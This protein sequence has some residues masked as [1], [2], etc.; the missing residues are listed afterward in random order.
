M[1]ACRACGCTDDNCSRCIERTGGRCWWV[2]ADLCSACEPDPIKA[3]TALTMEASARMSAWYS[4]PGAMAIVLDRR[5]HLHLGAALEPGPNGNPM[6]LLEHF[7]NIAITQIAGVPENRVRAAQLERAACVHCRQ[8]VALVTDVEAIRLHA[9]TCHQSPVVQ[10]LAGSR[11]KHGQLREL[12]EVETRARAAAAAELER[13]KNDQELS[14]T[15][16]ATARNELVRAL[17]SEPDRTLLRWIRDT[18]QN[19]DESHL[20][21]HYAEA[22]ALLQRLITTRAS[23]AAA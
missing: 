2:E 17:P 4:L 21:E 12:L 15:A 16:L 8:E 3:G 18:L 19:S 14:V 5:G 9:M 22:L 20:S 13:L 11:R 6:R 7:I 1:S 23:H 10:Q